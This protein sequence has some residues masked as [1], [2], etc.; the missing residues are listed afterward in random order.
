MADNQIIEY[1]PQEKTI[2]EKF[3]NAMRNKVIL[4][5]ASIVFGLVLVIW[6]RSA[7]DTLVRI[8]G[9]ILVA[10]AAVFILMY[11]FKQDKKPG[12]L[13]AGIIMAIV[14]AF[15]LIRPDFIVTLF[16]FIMGIILIVSGVFDLANIISMPKGM[17]GK[18]GITVVS[19]VIIA[20]GILCMFHPGAIANIL[21]LFIGIMYL[22]NGVFD[23]VVLATQSWKKEQ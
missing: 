12:F 5:V 15:F 21:I 4:A 6:Q 13:V 22:F 18:T 16:P 14:G 19:I 17:Q 1:T 20:M 23:L 9:I 2:Q 8:L 7:V 10:V 3:R 11:I